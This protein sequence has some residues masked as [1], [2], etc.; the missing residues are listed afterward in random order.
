MSYKIL[1]MEQ[2][3]PEWFEARSKFV[4]A[5]EV[6]KLL[7]NGRGGAPSKTRQTYLYEKVAECLVGAN[8]S[9]FK[10]NAHTERGNM[11]E[12]LLR[13]QYQLETGNI[14]T[15]IG[16]AYNDF[17]GCSPD[18]LIG[19]DGGIEIKSKLPHLQIAIID[20][21]EVP[22][23]HMAQIQA[24]LLVTGAKWWDFVS[25]SYVRDDDNNVVS[26]LPIF[27]KRVFPD[28]EMHFLIK[29]KVL[30]FNEQRDEMV[31]RLLK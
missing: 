2:G 16:F 18:G 27:I 22:S 8:C 20:K 10:G 14:C 24:C 28:L 13:A 29:D 19:K 3:T 4:T 25:G 7:S 21:Q 15:E 30:L 11:D 12:P 6:H 5:S 23:E 26:Q 1:N 17:M 9:S 31:K